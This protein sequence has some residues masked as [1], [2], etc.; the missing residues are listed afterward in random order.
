MGELVLEDAR[1]YVIPIFLVRAEGEG[2]YLESRVFLGTAF[3]VTKHGD[4]IT[5]GHII[6]GPTSPLL[7]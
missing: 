7:E 5:V 1:E 3:F 2:V 4:A 6:V